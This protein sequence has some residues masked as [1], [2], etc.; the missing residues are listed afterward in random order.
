MEPD[1][2]N[3]FV[4]G[5]LLESVNDFGCCNFAV[6]TVDDFVGPMGFLRIDFG[7]LSGWIC[8]PGFL[9]PP[10]MTR[11]R[12]CSDLYFLPI[13]RCLPTTEFEAGIAC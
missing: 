12:S 1:F 10:I 7:I 5:C 3:G 8:S 2:D 4:G 11:W 13:S 6:R 9:I